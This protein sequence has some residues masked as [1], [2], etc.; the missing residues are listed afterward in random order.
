MLNSLYYLYV[1]F[2]YK[3]ISLIYANMGCQLRLK[4]SHLVQFGFDKIMPGSALSQT[5]YADEQSI[6]ENADSHRLQ[7]GCRCSAP[8]PFHAIVSRNTNR[9]A[10]VQKGGTC[11]HA[12]TLIQEQL[13]GRSI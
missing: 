8:C 12:T 7:S 6:A 2:A 3:T 13:T 10:I 5:G 9:I 1:V 4:Y 11:M